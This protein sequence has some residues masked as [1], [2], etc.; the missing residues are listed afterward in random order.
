MMMGRLKRNKQIE[1]CDNDHDPDANPTQRKENQIA[2]INNQIGRYQSAE[3]AP[4]LSE[5]AYVRPPSPKGND[6]IV[7]ADIHASYLQPEPDIPHLAFK[8][9]TASASTAELAPAPPTDWGSTPQEA[10]SASGIN[11][12]PLHQPVPTNC[13]T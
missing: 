6:V 3:R 2:M 4:S 8:M 5:V 7:T 13:Y 10:R 11:R 1:K 9:L 12:Q